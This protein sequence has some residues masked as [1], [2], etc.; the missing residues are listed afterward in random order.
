MKKMNQQF[1]KL[2]S[3]LQRNK[4]S[5]FILLC[6]LVISACSPNDNNNTPNVLTVTTNTP[7]NIT[8]T[9][10]TLGGN[11]TK[12][13]G[14]TVT[15]KGI[16]IGINANPTIDDANDIAVEMGNG[17]GSFSDDFYP[18]EPS[19]TY[20][21]RAYATNADGTVYGEDKTRE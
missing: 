8:D 19:T 20:H 17:L 3:F 11:V 13:G 6:V 21:V 5:L 18:F 2:I 1:K 12:D 16:C 14:K 15:S 9:T 10:A 7:S 4:G